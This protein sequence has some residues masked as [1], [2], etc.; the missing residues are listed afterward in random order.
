MSL[1]VATRRAL[2][3]S[4]GGANWYDDAIAAY[5]PIGADDLADSYLN[6]IN[7]G[8]NDAAP[9]VAPT[10]TEGDGWTF[11][12]STQYLDS[13]LVPTTDG[14]WSVLVR[15]SDG[16][17]EQVRKT[18]LGLKDSTFTDANMQVTPMMNEPNAYLLRNGGGGFLQEGQR[19]AAGIFGFAGLDGWLNGIDTGGNIEGVT[20]ATNT[21]P[22]YIGA[23]NQNGT[24]TEFWDGKIQAIGIWSVTLS[25]EAMAAK[26]A[27]ME[28]L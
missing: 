17:V 19:F 12:G 2:L 6:I 13:T 24:A 5:Q 26:T 18:V 22:L 9:G 21:R 15:F 11:N 23:N 20:S 28:A 1:H 27:L 25:P 4:G 3:H 7:P 8:T 14:T 16:T 10:W